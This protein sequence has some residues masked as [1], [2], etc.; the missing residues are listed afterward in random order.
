MLELSDRIER[1]FI[2]TIDLDDEWEIETD[3]GWESIT[4]IH[5]TIPYEKWRLITESGL[6]LICADDHIVFTNKYE[7]IFVKDILVNKT[8]ILT[9]NGPETVVSLENLHEE[10]NMFDITVDSPNHRFY[11]NG[12]LSHNTTIV[13]AYLTWVVLFTDNQNILI[14]ANKRQ[15]AEDILAK[16][17]L[18]YENVPV[19]LQQGVDE[20]NKGNIK[21]ENGSKIRATSTTSSAARS[22]SY[23]IVLLDEFAHIETRVAEDFYTSVYPVISSGKST[24]IFIISTPKGMNLF[25]KF[26]EDAKN[27]KSD[28]IPF[29]VHW[30]DVPGRD[31]K[32]YHDTLRA[33]GDTRF[34]QEFEC[35]F[36]GSTDTLISGAKLQ[37]LASKDPR[38]I[39]NEINIYDE[40]IY[41]EWDDEGNSI[42]IEHK[43]ACCVDTSEGKKL[44]SSAFTIIDITATPY[45]VVATYASNI[46][47]PLLYPSIIYSACKYYNDAYVL[48]ESMTVGQQVADILHSDLEYENILRTSS[49]NKKSQQIS[50]GH[51]P[52]ALMGVKT[53]AP[54]KRIGCQNLKTLIETDQLL[55]SDKT[56]VD[57]LTTFVLNTRGSYEA[58]SGSHD[59]LVMTLVLFAWLSTQK[60]FKELVTHDLR[61]QLKQQFLDFDDQEMLPAMAMDDGHRINVEFLDH[62]LWVSNE[63]APDAYNP[64]GRLWS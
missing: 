15:T 60:Y 59:D 21:L 51:L 63:D 41:E 61:K 5:Q 44:D 56:I 43:Y 4:H 2:D 64:Y 20:W 8:M 9:Q 19:W 28:Y 37:Q 27:K 40:P 42:S 7:Q 16:L 52:G 53:T 38:T 30:S 32:W 58:E 45:K 6:E 55:I 33:I 11:T 39:R 10:E 29:E 24:K 48:I 31:V 35:S 17:Q 62:N 34:Q 22:G 13:I 36:L 12:I 14:A 25:Y 54:V 1:K 26:W 18:A 3:T 50:A 49:G 46:I 23:N 47:A 57:E